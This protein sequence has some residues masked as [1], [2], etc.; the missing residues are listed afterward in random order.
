MTVELL[1]FEGCPHYAELIP[2]LRSLIARRA[3]EAELVL[4]PIESLE[5][6]EHER[7]L[8]S[9]TVRVDGV[10]VDPGAPERL[11]FGLQCRIYRTNEGTSPLPPDAWIAGALESA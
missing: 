3:P 2:R 6:A 10:D 5:D 7:F 4:H 11:D 8:G 1:Y 9:P